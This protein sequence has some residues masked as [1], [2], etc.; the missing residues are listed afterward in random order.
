[1]R[2][3]LRQ[4]ATLAAEY[5]QV[6]SQ[7]QECLELIR[8]CRR[9]LRLLIQLRSQHAAPLSARS[10]TL[11]RIDSV[12]SAAQTALDNVSKLVESCRPEAHK[13]R[14]PFRNKMK[15]VLADSHEFH[16]QRPALHRHH[17]AVQAELEFVRQA[18]L[19][20]AFGQQNQ[21]NNDG[22]DIQRKATS[23]DDTKQAPQVFENYTL[24]E[25]LMGEISG[26]PAWDFIIRSRSSA[27]TI[28]QCLLIPPVL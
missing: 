10:G 8:D 17:G 7:V 9:D 22:D 28:Y 23:F 15:W 2:T 21:K 27:H 4:V 16:T 6:P 13:G 25:D 26:T 20:P 12:I 5:S 1:M 19:T 24:L 18:A 3:N 14:T 11:E